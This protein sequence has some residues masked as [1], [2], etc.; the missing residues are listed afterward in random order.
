M[1]NG[2][3]NSV[4]SPVFQ[5]NVLTDSIGGNRNAV[6]GIPLGLRPALVPRLINRQPQIK[7]DDVDIEELILSAEEGAD[8]SETKQ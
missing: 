7:A 1:V 6:S 2:A 3:Y 5:I 4:L 8:P